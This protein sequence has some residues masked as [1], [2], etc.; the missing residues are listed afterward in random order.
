L[1]LRFG[2]DGG[3]GFRKALQPVNDRN[4][5]IFDATIFQFIHDA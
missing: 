5:H 1:H 3:D 4:E 2:E